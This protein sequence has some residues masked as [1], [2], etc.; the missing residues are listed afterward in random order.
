MTNEELCIACQAGETNAAEE[1]IAANF[2][3]IRSVALGF[4]RVF[5]DYGWMRM[6]SHRKLRWLCCALCSTLILMLGQAF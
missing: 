3:F 5:R 4:E 6:I 1:L 2:P